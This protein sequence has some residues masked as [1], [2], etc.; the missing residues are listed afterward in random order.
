MRK[1]VAKWGCVNAVAM[2]STFAFLSLGGCGGRSDI[3]RVSGTITLEGQPLANARVIFQPQ[4]AG[5]ASYGVTDAEGHYTLQYNADT[6]GAMIGRHTVSVSTF[7]AGDPDAD[8]PGQISEERIPAKYNATSELMAEVTAGDNS[9]DFA[10]EAGEPTDW[11]TVGS[12]S[13]DGDN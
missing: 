8:P 12:G 2:L 5:S 11:Q 6:E 9:I 7:M 4:A 13:N 3:G 1:T 10:L